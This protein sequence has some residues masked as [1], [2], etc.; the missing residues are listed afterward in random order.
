A[1]RLP[2][3]F[4]SLFAEGAF[5]AA[6]V[7]LY[8]KVRKEGGDAVARLFVGE[9]LS[10]M[11]AILLPFTILAIVFMPQPM[12]V[13]APGLGDNTQTV[14]MAVEYGRITFPYLM[15]VSIVSLLSGV[16]NSHKRFG[17][18]AAS[19]I[20]FNL[21]MIAALLLSPVVKKEPGWMMSVAVFLAGFV[22]WFWLD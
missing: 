22:Q 19:P 15:L 21:L 1:L 3:L 11:I 14:E 2:S 10:V 4:R 17:P 9:A 7:P 13:L 5:S 12:P 20:Y 16:L 18:G 6:F 8:A